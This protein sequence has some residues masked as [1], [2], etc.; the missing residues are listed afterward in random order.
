MTNRPMPLGADLEAFK[1]EAKSLFRSVKNGKP[2][3]LKRVKPYFEDFTSAKLTQMQLVVAREYGFASWAKLRSQLKILKEFVAAQ[4][5]LTAAQDAL[6]RITHRMSGK[7]PLS[8]KDG[9]VLSCSFCGAT[10]NEVR[11]LIAGPSV[12][13]CDECVEL[14]NQVIHEELQE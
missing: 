5:E 10:Q 12:Y 13:V 6:T 14:C 2:E 7:K 4:E 8:S 11:K 3:A 9:V 1:N